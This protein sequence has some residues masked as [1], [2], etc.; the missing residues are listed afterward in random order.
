MTDQDKKQRTIMGGRIEIVESDRS[1]P[2]SPMLGGH[3]FRS[4]FQSELH[5]DAIR[6]L[7]A[8]GVAPESSSRSNDVK[9]A[10]GRYTL[11]IYVDGANVHGN[12]NLDKYFKADNFADLDQLKQSVLRRDRTYYILD[13]K[14]ISSS[15][16]GLAVPLRRLGVR[17]TMRGHT[18]D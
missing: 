3:A 10:F 5:H 6:L 15:E 14:L 17:K 13:E 2:W 4:N 7:R 11:S 12:P 18:R 16:T 1:P 9:I 8:N